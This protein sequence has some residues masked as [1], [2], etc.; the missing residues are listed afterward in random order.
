MK[1]QR[2][3]QFPDKR[4]SVSEMVQVT[5]KSIGAIRSII[6]LPRESLEAI[7]RIAASAGEDYLD[8]LE[9]IAPRYSSSNSAKAISRR[10]R[11]RI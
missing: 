8:H 11:S 6:E 1:S 7:K 9:A 2:I 5:T 4:T 10:S 3:V